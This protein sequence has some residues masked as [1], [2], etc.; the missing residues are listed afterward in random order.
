MQIFVKIVLSV[1]IILVATAIGKKL[2]STQ[3][4]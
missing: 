1:A 3:P 4:G 2:P